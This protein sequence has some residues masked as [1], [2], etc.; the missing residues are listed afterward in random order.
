[1]SSWSEAVT[2]G[3]PPIKGRTWRCAGICLP[4]SREEGHKKKMPKTVPQGKKLSKKRKPLLSPL[5]EEVPR[6]PAA[7]A[8]EPSDEEF[9][10]RPASHAGSVT[11]WAGSISSRASRQ[12]GYDKATFGRYPRAVPLVL[13]DW[14]EQD[15]ADRCRANEF[16][17]N[18]KHPQVPMQG[19]ERLADA[20]QG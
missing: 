13:T 15:V 3:M 14:Q 2:G 8:A 19:D 16:L 4:L 10:G 5:P 7:A 1:M 11:S 6:T 20:G 12:T 17:Y 18:M 9:D